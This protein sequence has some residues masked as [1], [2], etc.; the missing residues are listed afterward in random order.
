[1]VFGNKNEVPT[2]ATWWVNL[3]NTMLSKRSYTQKVAYCMIPFIQNVHNRQ[4][5]RDNSR[6]GLA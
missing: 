2:H 3:K 6:L 5:H 1:M 4:I